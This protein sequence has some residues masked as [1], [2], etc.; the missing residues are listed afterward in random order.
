MLLWLLLPTTRGSTLLYRRLVHP[1]LVSREKEIDAALDRFANTF[2]TPSNPNTQMAARGIHPGRALLQG[3][4]AEDHEDGGGDGP[5]G[6][7]GPGGHPAPLLQYGR[8]QGH[9]G[10]PD[11]IPA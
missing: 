11:T 5:A 6:R 7:R 1:L 2:S 8:P 3:G 9:G 10:K 4:G